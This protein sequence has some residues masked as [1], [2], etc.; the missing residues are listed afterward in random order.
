MQI[1]SFGDNLHEMS[2]PIFLG[3]I[4]KNIITLS[5]AEFAHSVVSVNK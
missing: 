1:V 3:K 5:S 4:R 2:D